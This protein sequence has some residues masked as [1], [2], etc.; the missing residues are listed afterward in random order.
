MKHVDPQNTS[1]QKM[2]SI[3]ADFVPHLMNRRYFFL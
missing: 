1:V 3:S 2:T